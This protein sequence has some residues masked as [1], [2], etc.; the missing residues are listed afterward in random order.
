M[1]RRSGWYVVLSHTLSSQYVQQNRKARWSVDNS[2]PKV[3][4]ICVHQNHELGC[5]CN[6]Q[7]TVCTSSPFNPSTCT[8]VLFSVDERVRSD[9]IL[10]WCQQRRCSGYLLCDIS[11]QPR[12][13]LF[14]MVSE[15]ECV[16]ECYFQYLHSR[17]RSF[18]FKKG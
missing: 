3:P 17:N 7:H 2:F 12:L 9:C 14:W 18:P 1:D 8:H 6:S 11:V 15:C 16:G 5:H 4:F 13:M 10:C